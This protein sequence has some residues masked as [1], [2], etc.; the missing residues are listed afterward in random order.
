MPVEGRLGQL[1]LVGLVGQPRELPD[2]AQGQFALP[3][4]FQHLGMDLSQGFQALDLQLV[5]AQRRGDGGGVHPGLAQ[6][7]DGDDHLGQVGGNVL[8]ARQQQGG[9]LG[10]LG[11]GQ[12]AVELV[13]LGDGAAFEQQQQGHPAAAAV[14]RHQLQLALAAGADEGRDDDA[15][16]Q[17]GVGQL[18][19]AGVRGLL[20]A[21]AFAGQAEI[22]Q[23][24]GDSAKARRGGDEGGLGDGG[25][26]LALSGHG[27]G[28]QRRGRGPSCPGARPAPSSLLLPPPPKPSATSGPLAATR[29]PGR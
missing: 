7:A 28:F 8:G 18:R 13:V 24:G 6:L 26:G 20:E 5:I 9:G 3:E 10:G 14:Q 29:S 23:A 12:Q 11:L 2:L 22:A 1:G 4:R 25:L 27:L 17:D 21:D 16:G 19:N 15:G